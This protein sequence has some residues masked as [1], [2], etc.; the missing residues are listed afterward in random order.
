MRRSCFGDPETRWIILKWHCAPDI[1]LVPPKREHR[2]VLRACSFDVATI[3]KTSQREP[4]DLET[5]IRAP[6]CTIELTRS[7]SILRMRKRPRKT[8]FCAPQRGCRGFAQRGFQ[9][10]S[11]QRSGSAAM[12]A[13]TREYRPLGG[14]QMCRRSNFR[15]LRRPTGGRPR[16]P[17]CCQS[18]SAALRTDPDPGQKPAR[19]APVRLR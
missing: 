8:Q 16:N 6:Q 11:S 9:V 14:Q 2:C 19:P 10:L 1:A 12:L 7:A 4:S 3:D 5:A 17:C 18:D 13:I 15:R